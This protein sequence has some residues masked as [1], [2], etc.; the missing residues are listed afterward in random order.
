MSWMLNVTYRVMFGLH[1]YDV[2][3]SFRMYKG[4]QIR[5]ISTECNNFDIVEE[6]LIKLNYGYPN[7]S[8]CEVPISFNKR[9]S[10]VSK[11]DLKKFILSYVKTMRR[12]L[13]IKKQSK[14]GY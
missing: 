14:I 8:I 13:N 4:E 5:A 6:L 12:L 1:I 11:R 10:G 7:F 3:D 9:V 2:S